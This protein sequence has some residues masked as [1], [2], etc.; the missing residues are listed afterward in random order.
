MKTPSFPFQP[1][2]SEGPVFSAPWQASAFGMVVALHQQGAFSWEEWAEQL[3]KQILKA[4]QAGDPDLGDT[5][6][7]HWLHALEQLLVNK[8]VTSE[9]EVSARVGKWRRAYLATPHGHPIE[10]NNA[11]D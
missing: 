10:L 8:Q 2:D 11:S 3:S 5:Y 7:S 1:T 6:Y 9:P 4:Q